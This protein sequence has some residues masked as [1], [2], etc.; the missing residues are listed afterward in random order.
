MCYE[1]DR[2]DWELSVTRYTL[3]R[4]CSSGAQYYRHRLQSGIHTTQGSHRDTYTLHALI[5]VRLHDF[6][7][8][9]V[10]SWHLLSFTPL[11]FLTICYLP[12]LLMPTKGK[13]RC[14][15]LPKLFRPSKWRRIWSVKPTQ[16]EFS[17]HAG[18]FCY[19]DEAW[20]TRKI[21]AVTSSRPAISRATFLS[22]DWPWESPNMN[23]KPLSW[24]Y[25]LCILW[26]NRLHLANSC[27]LPPPRL[28]LTAVFFSAFSPAIRALRA[29]S[30]RIA[31]E[32]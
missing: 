22:H 23:W 32:V 3:L 9:S 26:A 25:Y 30:H 5:V 12:V 27:S 1:T 2:G 17:L 10:R 8:R 11:P 4:R 16:V 14:L 20:Q 28:N 21:V 7:S 6:L 15:T 13:K 29:A 24:W 18:V 31:D 19:A